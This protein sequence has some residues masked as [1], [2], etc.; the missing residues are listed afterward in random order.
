MVGDVLPADWVRNLA[1][2]PRMHR[3]LCPHGACACAQE[4]ASK[5]IKALEDGAEVA[6]VASQ[7]HEQLLAQVEAHREH[8]AA[9]EAWA[10][11]WQEYANGLQ[12]Q[13]RPPAVCQRS[14]VPG[15]CLSW[16][17]VSAGEH[18]RR[19]SDVAHMQSPAWAGRDACARPLRPM[20]G[21]LHPCVLLAACAGAC[22]GQGGRAVA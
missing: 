11:Q 5:K 19:P 21:F 12:A 13:A 18:A 4:A 20:P 3:P 10:V 1:R 9:M 14:A 2:S 16:H 22:L 17:G 7:E 6:Q 8:S 15:R